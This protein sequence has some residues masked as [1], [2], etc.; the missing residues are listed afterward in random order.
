MIQ[1]LDQE[2]KL[3]ICAAAAS[4]PPSDP[5]NDPSD[6]SDPND[7]NDDPKNDSEN[8]KKI[9]I[10]L[11]ASALLTSTGVSIVVYSNSSVLLPTIFIESGINGI[12]HCAS[13]IQ[14]NEKFEWKEWS[15][16]IASAAFET[17]VIG[18]A[19]KFRQTVAFK[20]K[21]QVSKDI[22]NAL[23]NIYHIIE[24]FSN[25]IICIIKQNDIEEIAF[26]A[27]KSIDEE[28]SSI[29]FSVLT[30]FETKIVNKKAINLD[31]PFGPYKKIEKVMKNIRFKIYHD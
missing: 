28:Y 20:I 5:D 24:P 13:T 9:L 16:K 23:C 17:L 8:I 25:V 18:A 19:N 7:P 11:L 27:L 12:K 26:E 22:I 1:K 2:K 21:G 14:K 31:S 29:I 30:V 10:A 6:P 3:I 15:Y 4:L